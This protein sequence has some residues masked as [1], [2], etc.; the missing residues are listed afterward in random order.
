MLSLAPRRGFLNNLLCW[1]QEDEARGVS[2][3]I[4]ISLGLLGEIWII[5]GRS[6]LV[7]IHFFLLSFCFNSLYV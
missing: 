7:S 3:D 2:W 1:R 4:R 6:M 5:L